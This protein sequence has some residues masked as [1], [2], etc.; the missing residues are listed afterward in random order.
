[1]QPRDE[2]SG[3]IRPVALA[4]LGEPNKALSS[5]TELRFG[6]RG[7]MSVDLQ[8][9]V[10]HDH[11]AGTGGGVLDLVARHTGRANGAAVDWLRE[12]GF[13]ADRPQEPERQGRRRIVG[14]YDYRDESG[15]LVFQVVR[16]EPKDFRQRR[17]D[18]N[19][20]WSWSVK[21]ARP[22]LYRLFE[23][24]AKVA[25]NR[26]FIVEGEKDVDRLAALGLVATT[27]AGGSGKWP[28]ELSEHLAGCDVVLLPDNDEPGRGHAERVARALAGVAASIRVVELPG[29]PPKGDASDWLD[30]GGSAAELVRLVNA[31][32]LWGAADGEAAAGRVPLSAR[33]L[34]PSMWRGVP[35][36]AREWLV[37]DWIPA[38]RV[39]GLM[40]RGGVGKTLIAQQLQAACALGL[41]WL[42]LSVTQC[43]SFGIYCEDEPDEL[44]RREVDIANAY[45]ADLGDLDAMAMVSGVGDDNRLAIVDPSGALTFTPFFFEL[46]AA[47]R[48]HGARLIVLDNAGDLFTLNQNDDVHARLAVNSV[49]GRLARNLA[50]TVL[51]L[52]H[53]SRAGLTSGD[54]D[55]GSVAW[56]NAFRS[57]LYLDYEQAAEGDE[58]D[59]FA[60]VLSHRKSNYGAQSDDI[61]LRWQAGVLAPA[62]GSGGFVAGIEA[63]SREREVD[64]AF[65]ACLREVQARGQYA[66]DA[67]ASRER[68][69]P[70]LFR[71]MTVGRQCSFGE[72]KAAMQRLLDAG[73]IRVEGVRAAGRNFVSALVEVAT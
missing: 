7:S 23:L 68:Y 73:K 43:R 29:L 12:Q 53:P 1:M 27:N 58:P 39:S 41:P 5:A 71:T 26:V 72:H 57:R 20:G 4:L 21:G 8:R 13:I 3:C 36:P 38:G 62:G 60:R 66:S 16:F 9:G 61:K 35:V 24:R 55:A 54:G 49:C 11:E 59:K 48:N 6:S 10:W 14:S 45:G 31:A 37:A 63:R 15:A 47:A 33:I 40:G 42:G 19:G 51:L 25:H 2:F 17:P 65:L 67:T 22:L 70:K 56:T 50:A 30:A 64:A 69:A 28:A 32:P 18:G 52:R 34:L 46:E 44:H